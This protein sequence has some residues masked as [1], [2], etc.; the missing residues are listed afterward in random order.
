MK[1]KNHRPLFA[2]LLLLVVLLVC[3]YF[4]YTFFLNTPSNQAEDAVEEFYTYEQEGAFSNSW[5]MFHPY[6]KERFEKG[7]YLQDRAHV[8]LNHFGVNTFTFSIEHAEVIHDWQIEEDA[9][10]IDE[11][12]HIPVTQYYQGK[13]GNFSIVQDVF[14]TNLDGEWTILWDY[15]KSET[16]IEPDEN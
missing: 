13:Y 3:C 1:R 4:I 14:V 7:Y 11:V 5:E 16:S 12:Y 10:T 15:K 9:E 8:F 6:M 2:V